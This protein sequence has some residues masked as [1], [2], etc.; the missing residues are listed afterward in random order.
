M[1]TPKQLPSGK[2]RVQVYNKATGKRESITA[3]TRAKAMQAA[4]AYYEAHAETPRLTFT[5][6]A[7]AYMDHRE[8]VWSPNTV[9]EYRRLCKLC[10]EA[11]GEAAVDDI[12]TE[13]LQAWI[14]AMAAIYT[15]KT[16]RN[17]YG[18]AAAVINSVSERNHHVRLP[19]KEVSGFEVPS[20]A[21]MVGLLDAAEGTAI[22]I[23]ILLAA[24]GPMRRSEI[25]ALETGD[26]DGDVVHVR[27]A[28]AKTEALEWVDKGP[29]TYS[30]DRYIRYPRQVIDAIRA[31]CSGPVTSKTPDGVT[32]SF[33][34]LSAKI[35]FK[36]TFHQLRHWSVSYLHRM[37]VPEAEI[38][39]RAGWG[40]SAIF[41]EVYRHPTAGLEVAAEV[42]DKFAAGV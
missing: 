8:R 28:M 31:R 22:E 1:P 17:V 33:E 32:R 21:E 25:C 10:C 42:F 9:R 38:L 13:M 2:W 3:E 26:I 30:G 7:A 36:Y 41:R 37:G 6:A 20:D 29:K 23:P 12:T 24:Y 27:R 4:D 34:K 35:G 18:F 16:V 5:E 39:K 15:P 40:S 11:L 19:Q 14:N